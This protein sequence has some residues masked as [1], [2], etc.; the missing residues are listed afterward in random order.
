MAQPNKTDFI[1]RSLAKIRHKRWEMFVVSRILHRLDDVD[2]EFVTQQL[3]RLPDRHALTDLYFP[4]FGLHL[5]VDEGHH[6]EPVNVENDELRLR[7]IVEAT[8][9]DVARIPVVVDQDGVK[10]ERPLEDICKDV[11]AFIERI[12]TLKESGQRDGTFLP[13][14]FEERYRPEPHIA[15]GY[16]SVA[17]GVLFKYQIDA[18]RCFGFTGEGWQRGAWR[19]KDGSGDW[20]WF[21]RLYPHGMWNNELSEDGSTIYERAL[22][23]EGRAS[24]AKQLKDTS[25]DRIVFARRT[26]SLGQTL[27]QYVGTFQVNAAASTADVIQFD[28]V[29]QKEQIR[30]PG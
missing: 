12:R 24:I 28:R 7:A 4:Q 13:W 19:I 21:P 22:G 14:D 18:L 9:H 15:K 8:A 6:L 16:V 27:Y 23:E 5:E 10:V 11:E 1:L 30:L 20:V 2:I 17:D 3:V 26:D 25:G 29:R